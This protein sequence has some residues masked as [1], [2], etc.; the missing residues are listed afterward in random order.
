MPD[1]EAEIVWITHQVRE[2]D[3]TAALDAIRALPVV[4]SVDNWLR[5]E[6]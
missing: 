6:E 5:V 2:R 1:E 4:R 3:L